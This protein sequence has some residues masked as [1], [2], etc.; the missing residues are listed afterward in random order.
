MAVNCIALRRNAFY[1][2]DGTL[3]SVEGGTLYTTIERNEQDVSLNPELNAF[4][5]YIN[6]LTDG[7]AI[8]AGIPPTL[9]EA[10][11]R[12][13]R[14]IEQAASSSLLLNGFDAVF[15]PTEAEPEDG[16]PTHYN[17]GLM[18][19]V[20]LL[21][22]IK[23]AELGQDV[24]YICIQD[25]SKKVVVHTLAQLE[26]AFLA[27]ALVKEAALAQ[28]MTLSQQIMQATTVEEVYAVTWSVAP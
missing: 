9:E 23:L 10:Q 25:G 1:N 4:V 7:W 28:V 18:D 22:A 11:A 21:E 26:A 16:I 20:N 12:Q 27:G 2:S 19:Q 14:V 13:L 6:S 17:S 15:V 8:A 5:D 24:P 3:D